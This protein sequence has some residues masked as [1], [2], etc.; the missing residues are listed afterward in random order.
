VRYQK[1]P[2]HRRGF[3]RGSSLWLAPDHLLLVKSLRFREEYQRFY[4]RDIQ[5]IGIADGPRFHLSTRSAFVAAASR[6]K[7]ARI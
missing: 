5:S 7:I 2:G 6:E 1:L 3:L 4:F